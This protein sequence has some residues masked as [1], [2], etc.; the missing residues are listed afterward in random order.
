MHGRIRSWLFVPFILLANTTTSNAACIDPKQLAHS[1]VSIMRYF[2][3]DE[4]ETHRG[5]TGVRGT[6]WFLSP[7]AIVTAEHVAAAMT[8]STEDWKLLEIVDG[9]GSQFIAGRLQRL[10]GAQSERLAVIELQRAVSNAQ[11]VAIRK[12]PLVPEEQVIT[13]TYP[14]GRPHLVGGRFVRVG[15]DGKLTG[16]A[17]LELYE[18]ENRLV[19]DHGASGAPVVDCDGRVAAVVSDIFTQTIHW[20]QRE[21]RI[22]TAW[23]MPNVV[24]VP[25]QALDDLSQRN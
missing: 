22:S 8:L 16:M 6:A 5:L 23:G 9:D 21:I 4:R 19:V 25:I 18:G 11:S 7:T 24:S 3:D 17:L 15:D 14:G 10:A 20:A 1:A 13:F 12:K 2:D